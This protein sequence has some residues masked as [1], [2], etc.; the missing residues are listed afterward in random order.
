MLNMRRRQFI[1]LLG[2]AAAAWPLVVRAQHPEKLPTIGFLGTTDPSSMRPWITAF[3][4]RLR[5]LG[6]I[7]DR[8]IAI[9]YRWAEGHPERCAEIAAEF[10]RLN[11]NVIVT[12]GPAAPQ[13]KKAT[14]VIPI[15]LVSARG[16]KTAR[17]GEWTAVQV[18]DILRR[19]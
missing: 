15:V 4:E 2:G 10:V 6:W 19:A 7:E 18:S 12:T 1:S 17:G 5:D 11:V 3:V 9:A 8:T 13:A 14:S 16:V